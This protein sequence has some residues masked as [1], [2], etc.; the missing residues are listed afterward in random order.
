VPGS[1]SRP[2]AIYRLHL[3]GAAG[4]PRG[5][6]GAVGAAIIAFHGDSLVCWRFA[7][8]HGF[9]RATSAHINAAGAGRAG[10]VVVA[11]SRG[12]RL[13]HQGC[14][15]VSPAVSRRIRA[16]PEGYYVNVDSKSYVHG[17]VRAQL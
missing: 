6:T 3:S 14:A 15:P 13:H 12:P 1:G 10:Q 16:R 17:A 8:L 9:T 11:L 4:T 5:A 7:H 2:T